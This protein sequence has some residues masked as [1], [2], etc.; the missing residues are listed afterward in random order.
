MIVTSLGIEIRKLDGVR[1]LYREVD[2]VLA[3]PTS[4]K[5]PVS[6][7]TTAHALQK[8]L[9]PHTHFDVCTIRNCAQVCEICIPDNRMEIYR[10]IHCMNWSE[11]TPEYRET[12]IAMVLDDFR[13]VLS[14]GQEMEGK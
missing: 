11:M 12:V 14:M 5:V 7:A 3:K 4:Q 8:M 2:R 13:A 10:S 9:R 1:D 6:I